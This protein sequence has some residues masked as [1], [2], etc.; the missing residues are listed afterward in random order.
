VTNPS[1]HGD[2]SSASHIG[3]TLFAERHRHGHQRRDNPLNGHEYRT[4]E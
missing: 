4:I 3:R 1:S 2:L